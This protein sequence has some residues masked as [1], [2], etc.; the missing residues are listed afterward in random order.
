MGDELQPDFALLA[1]REDGLWSVAALPPAA[2]DDVD[3]LVRVLRQQ[4]GEVGAIGL[5]S[6]AEDFFLIVRVRGTDE[7]FLLSDCTA[8]FDAPLAAQVLDRLGLPM[9]D[10]DDEEDIEPAGDL[11]LLSD[12][13]VDTILIAELC[14][15]LELFPDDALGR[16]AEALGFSEQYDQAVD[17]VA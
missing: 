15:D 17:L 16:I 2:A 6:V 11:D 14:D 12:L 5:V 4:P 10:G 8:A 1:V 3:H 9:P 13:G 7:R